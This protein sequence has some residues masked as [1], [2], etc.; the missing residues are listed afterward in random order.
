[1]PFS[2]EEFKMSINKYNNTLTPRPDKLS[3]RHLKAIVNN[4][5]CHKSFINIANA[6][7]NL[8]Y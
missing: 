1:M 6:Y 3:W 7:I 8:G 5:S 4:K 2:K